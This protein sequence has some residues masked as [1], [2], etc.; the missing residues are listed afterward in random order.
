MFVPSIS[1][2]TIST[3]VFVAVVLLITATTYHLG[4]ADDLLESVPWTQPDSYGR[5][6]PPPASGSPANFD[7]ESGVQEGSNSTSS[8][9][10]PVGSKVV[11]LVFYGRR[12]L[13]RVLDCYL[14]VRPVSA[15]V[16]QAPTAELTC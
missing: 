12:E 4:L 14:K 11:G 7:G 9:P 15:H 10:T 3:L 16:A 8:I 6:P 13:V 5:P 2:R 1:S